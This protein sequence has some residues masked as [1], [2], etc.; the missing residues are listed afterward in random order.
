MMSENRILIILLFVVTHIACDRVDIFDNYEITVSCP[1]G[2]HYGGK[3]V[4]DAGV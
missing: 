3:E 4:M 1:A 2:E